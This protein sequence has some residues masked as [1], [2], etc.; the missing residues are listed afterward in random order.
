MRWEGGGVLGKE[1]AMRRTLIQRSPRRIA[2]LALV[3]LSTALSLVPN[4]AKAQVAGLGV[5]VTPAFD[6]PVVVGEQDQ[7]ALIQLVNNSFG[8]QAAIDPVTLTNLRINTSCATS[9]V[10]GA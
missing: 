8:P 1:H 2:L 4:P 10:D 5:G 9:A 6:S 7:P 3:L